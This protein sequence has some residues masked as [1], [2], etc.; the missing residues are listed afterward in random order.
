MDA[1]IGQI[2]LFAF[3]FAPYGWM[4]CSGQT[5][6]I[7]AY[8]PLYSLIGTKFGGDGKTTFMLPNLTGCEPNPN[9]CYYIATQGLYPS[10][11]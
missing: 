3:G 1:Y 11:G 2:Q 5:L 6:Q 4:Q 10:R 9:S 7:L 8:Q